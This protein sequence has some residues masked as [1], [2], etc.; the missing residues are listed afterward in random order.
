MNDIALLDMAKRYFINTFIG[1]EKS[2]EVIDKLYYKS[3]IQEIVKQIVSRQK[4]GRRDL[5]KVPCL[6]NYNYRNRMLTG[7]I[8]WRSLCRRWRCCL[9]AILLEQKVSRY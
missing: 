7:S 5:G 9:H 6:D 4:V 8:R 1:K 3:Q 2:F